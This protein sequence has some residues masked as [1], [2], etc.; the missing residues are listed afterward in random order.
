VRK[1]RGEEFAD[2]RWSGELPDPQ[3]EQ[4]FQRSK[5]HWDLRQEG[6][7]RVLLEFYKEL[8]R[9]RREIPALS[10][11][12]RDAQSLRVE[13]YD[14]AKA[15]LVVRRHESSEVFA[16]FNIGAKTAHPAWRIPIGLWTKRLDSASSRWGSP[17]SCDASNEAP[18][19]LQ[20]TTEEKLVLGPWSVVMYLKSRE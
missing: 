6:R 3:D 11:L 20:I 10:H 19:S 7:H 16:A 4:T 8:L 13:L 9:L 17:Q 12:G 5:L 1:G 18:E 14:E 2:F 15:I